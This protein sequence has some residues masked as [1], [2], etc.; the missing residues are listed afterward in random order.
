MRASARMWD[1]PCHVPKE[2]RALSGAA[3]V[4]RNRQRQRMMVLTRKAASQTGLTPMT[5]GRFARHGQAEIVQPILRLNFLP[6]HSG[7][8]TRIPISLSMIIIVS[9]LPVN[10]KGVNLHNKTQKSR[11][12]CRACKKNTTGACSCCGCLLCVLP[13]SVGARRQF[14]LRLSNAICSATARTSALSMR[15]TFGVLPHTSAMAFS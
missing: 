6:A 5:E 1:R 2:R 8:G 11:Y 3:V 14:S 7:H 10:A 12:I 4:S 13:M 9:L 15:T